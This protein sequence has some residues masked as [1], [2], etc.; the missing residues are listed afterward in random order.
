M[1]APE[2]KFSLYIRCYWPEQAIIEGSWMPLNVE[3]VK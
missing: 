1:P 2:G 3:K